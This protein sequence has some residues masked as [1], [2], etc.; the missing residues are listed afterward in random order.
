MA[1]MCGA[2]CGSCGMRERC[3]GC[4][5]TEGHPFGDE[6]VV[7]KCY[8][9]GGE[10]SFFEY[11]S[12]LIQEFN[13]LNIPDLPPITELLNGS[14]INLEYTLPSGQRVKLLRDSD[15]YLG[16]QVERPGSER[17]YGLSAVDGYLMV[18]EYGCG[19][20]DPQII[21]YKRRQPRID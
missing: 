19:G 12:Q 2:D 8:K 18:C 9:D 5:E 7:Y 11:K 15:I 1:S 14:Y 20:E 13:D 3:R 17:C 4:A 10:E 16:C 21:L 6:C